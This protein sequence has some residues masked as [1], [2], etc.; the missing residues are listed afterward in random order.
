MP[1]STTPARSVCQSVCGDRLRRAL[2]VETADSPVRERPGGVDRIDAQ[3]AIADRDVSARVAVPL[4]RDEVRPRGH[5]VG[6]EVTERVPS[7]R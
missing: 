4:D 5:V 3:R 6:A 2:V 7:L 1:V